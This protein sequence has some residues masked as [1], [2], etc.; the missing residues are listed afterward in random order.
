MEDFSL[1]GVAI[2]AGASGIRV[3][4]EDGFTIRP[5]QYAKNVELVE[6]AVAL[7]R[8][9]GFKVATVAE[10]REMLGILR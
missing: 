2:G 7:I 6:H 8:A 1:I 9:M 10:A 5:G 3:G 4:Y